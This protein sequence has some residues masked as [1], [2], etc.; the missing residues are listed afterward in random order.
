MALIHEKLYQSKN[1]AGIDLAEYIRCLADDLIRSYGVDSER[2]A[3]EI[4]AEEVFLKVDAAIPCGLLLHEL[5]SNCLKHAFPGG[6]PGAIRIDLWSNPE[7]HLCLLVR[8]NGVGLPEELDFLNT[9]SLGLQLVKM[10]AEQLDGTIELVRDTGTVFRITFA[11]LKYQK[12][13]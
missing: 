2:I 7:G 12:G 3:L 6:R 1:L 9:D 10:L 5:L 8:D 13:S 4:N 11:G